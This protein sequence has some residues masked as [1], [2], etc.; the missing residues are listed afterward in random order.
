MLSFRIF[1]KYSGKLEN[2]NTIFTYQTKSQKQNI[3]NIILTNHQQKKYP[4]LDQIPACKVWM[5]SKLSYEGDGCSG[6]LGPD[7]ILILSTVVI[8]CLFRG[9]L[10][11]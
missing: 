11:P 7:I 3:H 1:S 8:F 10:L 9:I 4:I 5:E 2:L 6:S